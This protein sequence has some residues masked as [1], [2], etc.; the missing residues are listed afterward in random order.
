[1]RKPPPRHEPLPIEVRFHAGYKV[2]ETNG[3]WEWRKAHHNHG[4]GAIGWK[5]PGRKKRA[6]LAHRIAGHLLNGWDLF[7]PLM[8]CHTCDNKQCVNP[9]HLYRGTNSDNIRDAFARG[10]MKPY[11]H[12]RKLY[13]ADVIYIRKLSLLGMPH[14]AIADKYGLFV[15]SV[16]RIV[17]RHQWRDV[18]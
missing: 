3:C 8:F 18:V 1:M 16:T 7:D 11:R 15:R 12:H 17:N 6:Y 14:R 4:Y 13:P 10:L 5:L 2:N 9:A